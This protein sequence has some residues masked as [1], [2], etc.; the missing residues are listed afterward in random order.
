MKQSL[1]PEKRLFQG[2]RRLVVFFLGR[3]K[4]NKKNKKHRISP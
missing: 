3:S 2:G 4:K 1:F